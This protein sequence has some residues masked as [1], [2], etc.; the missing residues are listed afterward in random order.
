MSAWLELMALP[1]RILLSQHSSTRLTS[2]AL[3]LKPTRACVCSV[4]I[5]EKD[6]GSSKLR[7][8]PDGLARIR[9]MPAGTRLAPVVVIGPYRSGKT[10]LSNQ[11]LN[12]TCGES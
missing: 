5:I 2:L 6:P 4:S 10:W 7:V 12:L 9:A 8:N 11:M 3:R 1:A